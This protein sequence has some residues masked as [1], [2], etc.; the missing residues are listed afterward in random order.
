[1]NKVI[2]LFLLL[3]LL[4]TISVVNAELPYSGSGLRSGRQLSEKKKKSKSAKSDKSAK[5]EKSKRRQL[6][7]KSDCSNISNAPTSA[8]SE[9]DCDTG[10]VLTISV[11][12]DGY[13]SE[14]SWVLEKLDDTAQEWSEVG[15]N[16]LPC[17]TMYE[18]QFCLDDNAT[19]RFTLFDSYG[20]GLCY[21]GVCGSYSVD[22]N[23]KEILSDG[24]FDDEVGVTFVTGSCD[25]ADGDLRV[26]Y[27]EGNV[28]TRNCG[29]LTNFLATKPLSFAEQACA[30]SVVDKDVIISDLCRSLCGPVGPCAV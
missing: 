14:S 1:M 27:Q 26:Q 23:G 10:E 15:S 21:D 19:Y 3:K 28:Y 20:D 2:S 9:F 25:D 18:D 24:P 22:L 12:T 29:E 16:D 4:A 8:P 13:P 6:I 7:S 11:E 17:T 5:S 30:A